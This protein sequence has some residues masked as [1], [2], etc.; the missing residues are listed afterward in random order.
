M[1]K[2]QHYKGQDLL[3]EQDDDPA[4]VRVYLDGGRPSQRGARQRMWVLT[5]GETRYS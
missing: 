1:A 3:K 4:D 2:F 5:T